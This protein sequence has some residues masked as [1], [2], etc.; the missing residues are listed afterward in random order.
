MRKFEYAKDNPMEILDCHAEAQR[1]LP[2]M[3]LLRL[4]I[5]LLSQ[6]RQCLL[7]PL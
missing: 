7:R 5:L 1:M 6:M 3:T 2:D 4:M